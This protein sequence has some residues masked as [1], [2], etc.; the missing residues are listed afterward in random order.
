[1]ADDGGS[2]EVQGFA[3]ILQGYTIALLAVLDFLDSEK[4]ISRRQAAAWIEGTIRKLPENIRPE[5]MTGLH[6]LLTSLRLTPVRPG[7]DLAPIFHVL[8]GGA[9]E[10]AQSPPEPPRSHGEGSESDRG[11]S[12]DESEPGE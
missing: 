1:M 12:S 11:G 6:T 8:Q 2:D 7:P 5:L 10:P 4:V 9:S 3:A